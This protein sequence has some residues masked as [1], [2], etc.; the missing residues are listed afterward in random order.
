MIPGH[1]EFHSVVFSVSLTDFTPGSSV[2]VLDFGRVN[3]HTLWLEKAT[4]SFL[5]NLN[6]DLKWVKS[7]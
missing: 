3:T 6:I 1:C 5:C 7:I 4:T 2:S